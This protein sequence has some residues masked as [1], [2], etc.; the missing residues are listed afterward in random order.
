MF[1]FSLGVFIGLNEQ[2]LLLSHLAKTYRIRD[3]KIEFQSS[4]YIDRVIQRWAEVFRKTQDLSRT[5][6]HAQAPTKALAGKVV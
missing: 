3:I 1:W 5:M 4:V 2:L 6:I